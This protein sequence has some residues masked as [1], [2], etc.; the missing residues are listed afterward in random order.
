MRAVFLESCAL[1]ERP[2]SPLRPS[3]PGSVRALQAGVLHP[4]RETK[5][6]AREREREE[7][8]RLRHR[9]GF[10]KIPR[11]YGC[12]IINTPGLHINMHLL[13]ISL[14]LAY[15]LYSNL[16]SDYYED[17]EQEQMDEPVSPR[18]ARLLCSPQ[19]QLLVLMKQ[20]DAP[21]EDV[22]QNYYMLSS[23]G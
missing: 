8:G 15:L 22:R 20:T 6:R 4:D 19:L 9:G 12:R 1:H 3:T 21:L 5:K 7:A 17:Y 18:C 11:L 2:Q 23:E 16:A 13:G 14:L 10:F